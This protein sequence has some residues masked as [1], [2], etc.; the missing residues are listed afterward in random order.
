[1]KN[2]RGSVLL[3]SVIISGLLL[4]LGVFMLK[5]VYN[6]HASVKAI[7]EREQAFWLAEGA[8]EAAKSKLAHNPSWFTDLIHYPDSDKEWLKNGAIG[9]RLVLG[10]GE[11]KM[12][13]E[14]GRQAVY[15]LGQKGNSVVILKIS[16]SGGQV[17]K[18]EEI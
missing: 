16:A 11:L 6:Y 1:M 8:L 10:G 3:L 14:R 13:R 9:E 12:I 2:R 5:I 15:G 7:V 18:W 17:N 4:I